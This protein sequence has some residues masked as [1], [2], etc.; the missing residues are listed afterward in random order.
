MKTL[1]EIEIEL[2]ERNLTEWSWLLEVTN[3]ELLRGLISTQFIS[4]GVS[5]CLLNPWL[6]P[7]PLGLII[8]RFRSPTWQWSRY[9]YLRHRRAVRFLTRSLNAQ[10][11][12][13]RQVYLEEVLTS[14]EFVQTHMIRH[15]F[16]YTSVAVGVVILHGLS[17]RLLESEQAA[18]RYIDVLWSWHLLLSERER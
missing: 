13:A 14:S 10:Y 5:L 4:L 12:T 16:D 3:Y 15:Y 9:I 2:R 11:R 8:I 1:S 17:G 7:V 6:A 18:R